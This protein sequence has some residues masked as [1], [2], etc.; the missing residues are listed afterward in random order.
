LRAK[1]RFED[2]ARQLAYL[3]AQRQV[4]CLGRLLYPS[5]VG[6]FMLLRVWRR[7][8]SLCLPVAPVL[9]CPCLAVASPSSRFA[10]PFGSDVGN[11]SCASL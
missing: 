9:F 5:V 11:S 4:W 3:Y 1:P 8:R 6:L 10:A 7:G 2:W